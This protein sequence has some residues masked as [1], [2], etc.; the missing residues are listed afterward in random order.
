[1]D[2]LRWFSVSQA[3]IMPLVI[4]AAVKGF[5]LF[6]LAVMLGCSP[7][8]FGGGL[9]PVIYFRCLPLGGFFNTA[10]RAANPVR[11]PPRVFTISSESGK[12]PI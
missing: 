5:H 10:I 2:K 4:R 1:M 11:K 7:P 6:L 12:Y 9:H 3:M 8:F